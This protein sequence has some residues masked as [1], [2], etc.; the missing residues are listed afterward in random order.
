MEAFEDD[1]DIAIGRDGV[2]IPKSNII[3]IEKV[4]YNAQRE[5]SDVIHTV[6][7]FHNEK[8]SYNVAL[9]TQW[10]SNMIQAAKK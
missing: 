2:T 9:P 5:M 1:I 8:S 4:S 7:S 3:S 6:T 10:T